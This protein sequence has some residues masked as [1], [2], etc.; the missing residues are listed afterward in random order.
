MKKIV[1]SINKKTHEGN[2][3]YRYLFENI[4]SAIVVCEPIFDGK[5]R[6]ID[7]KFI[8]AN[9]AVKKHLQKTPEK[10]IGR[11]YS[12][13]FDCSSRSS[14]FEICK[15]V[16]STG[17]PYNGEILLQDQNKYYDM[18]VSKIESRLLVITLFDVSERK[19]TEGY[20]TQE[21][22]ELRTIF[23]STKDLI[24]LLDKDFIIRR[25]N[26]AVSKYLGRP[27]SKVLGKPCYLLFHEEGK[28]HDLCPLEKLKQSKRHEEAQIYISEKNMWVDV[29]VD[30]IFDE[31]GNI[32]QVV[33][34][35]K[36]ITGRKKSEE[37]YKNL[38]DNIVDEIHLWRV[39]RGK[40][41]VI[42]AWSLVDVNPAGLKSWHKTREETIGKD[43][44]EI[45]PSPRVTKTLMPIVQ[46][47]F[48]EGKPHSW[49]S[50]YEGTK[51]YFSMTC[52]PFGEYFISIRRDITDRKNAEESLRKSEELIN[53]ITDNVQ[54]AIFA[55]D[56]E[57]KYSYVNPAAE[58]MIGLPAEKIVGKTAEE[59]F[60]AESASAIREV[61]DL[62][63]KGEKEDVI[64]NLVVGEHKEKRFLHTVQVPILGK[65]KKVVGIVG[66][67]KDVTT[68]KNTEERLKKSEILLKKTG[69]ISKIGGWEFDIVNNRLTWTDETYKLHEL[70]I[71]SRLDVETAMNFY[72]SGSRSIISEAVKKAIEKAQPYKL[73]LQL[74]TAKGNK[75][76]VYTEGQVE[77]VNGKTVKI[78]GI[79]QD[80]TERKNA[81]ETITRE[82]ERAENYLEVAEVIIVAIDNDARIKRINRKG[83]QLLG[84]REDELLGKNWFRFC[85]P[86]E[87]YED[88]FMVFKKIIAGEIKIFEYYENY[89]MSRTGERRLIAWRNTLLKDKNG[90][91]M[92]TLSSGEDITERKET[93]KKIMASEERFR[94]LVTATTEIVWVTDANGRVVDDLP[95]W[96]AY[97]GQ[98]VTQVLGYGW[99]DALHPD[100]RERTLE[101]WKLAVKNHASYQTE[102]RIQRRDGEYRYFSVC[103]VPIVDNDNAV[104]EWVGYCADITERRNMAEQKENFVNMLSHEIRTPLTVFKE[105][106]S[107]MLKGGVGSVNE[108]QKEILVASK[109][110]I[111]RLTRLINQVLDFQKMDFGMMHYDFSE[112]DINRVI[113]DIC[114]DMAHLVNAKG[115][116]LVLK[117][118]NKLPRAIFD[119]DKI[120]EVITNLVSNAINFTE[121]GD[122]TVTTSLHDNLIKVSVEDMGIGIKKENMPK[123]FQRFVQLDRRPGGTGLG[124]A[125]SKEIVDRHKGKI[126]AESPPEG[127]GEELKNGTVF[128]FVLPV[129]G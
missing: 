86:P 117:L 1:S 71:G 9:P 89:V 16:L 76:W 36:D 118:D 49:E 124:L 72:V 19:K 62:N 101:M 126:W 27:I 11:K 100:D 82:K 120:I 39:I 41:G 85:L 121:K 67:V 2:D 122:I 52:I 107:I 43:A 21:N 77:A 18:S 30:P 70:P 44:D 111:N 14:V 125:I 40:T 95:F 56:R 109:N 51:Q 63:F 116:K 83:C 33:H 98:T 34:V 8:M 26:L 123:L 61:D 114:K 102:Y 3:R 31:E 47:I 65:D 7:L 129:A 15:K 105:A 20:L 119:R 92:G 106:I 79:F 73:E 24:M 128:H 38:F 17:K 69:E 104:R 94:A 22:E 87:E 75:I 68:L 59:I 115:L 54:D 108:E 81:E 55:K 58:K 29:S 64:K 88:V 96:R 46:K 28:P 60:C 13:V 78:F 23:N 6:L 90:S 80:I 32:S 103:G 113:G 37:K 91:V 4:L 99:S 10:F 48:K 97:T 110:N 57:R 12:E 5:G 50:F 112:N 84:Y 74:V 35:M 66:I 127:K 53:S 45:F 25:A 93:E 42:K